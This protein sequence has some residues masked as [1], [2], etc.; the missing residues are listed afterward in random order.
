MKLYGAI[1]LHSRNNYLAVTEENDKRLYGRRLPNRPDVIFEALEPYKKDLAGIAVEST[2]N[3]YWLVDGLQEQGYTVQLVNPSAVKQYEG[4]KH[5]DDK[6]DAFWLCHL[7]RLGILPTGYIYPKETRP[8]RDLLRR[9]VLFVRHRTSH[10][11]STQSMFERVVGK[12][13]S[14]TDI[15]NLDWQ[16]IE[17]LFCQPQLELAVKSNIATIQFFNKQIKE[18]EKEVLDQV[19]FRDEFDMLLTIP[20][21]GK[22]LGLTIMLEVGDIGRFTTV[23]DYCSYCRCVKA[24]RLSDG[25][26]KGDNNR[27][28]GNKYL[29]WAYVE[30]AQFAR[31]YCVE[32]QMFYHRKLAKRNEAVAVK[33][34]SSKLARASY[35]LMRDRV[36][37][38]VKKLFR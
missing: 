35:Y 2:F 36:P 31:R 21:I 22:I 3:W 32:A 20:G 10:I 6:W 14:V 17:Q 1:D 37:F 28:N 16:E 25:K 24:V 8:V 9:R 27:K 29:S 7:L 38:D 34:L 18:I 30:A 26:K 12:H 11:L 33:A 23:G 4:L 19:K 15:N 5:A 13:L